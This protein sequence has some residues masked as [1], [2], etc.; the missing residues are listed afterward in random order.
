MKAVFLYVILFFTSPLSY[1]VSDPGGERDGETKDKGHEIAEMLTNNYKKTVSSCGDLEQPAYLCSGVMFRG[2]NPS[3]RYNSWDPSP[4]S[5]KSGGVSFSYLREDAEFN[6]LAFYYQNGFIIYNEYDIPADDMN[7]LNMLCFFPIDGHTGDRDEAGCGE[8]PRYKDVSKP[9]QD[10]GINTAQGWMDRFNNMPAGA[11]EFEYQCGFLVMQDGKYHGTT[12]F[13]QGVEAARQLNKKVLHQDNEVR[14]ATWDTTAAGYPES[15]PVAA[16]FYLYS[17]DKKENSITRGIEGAQHDQLS[18]YKQTG[19]WVPIIRLTLPK[20]ESDETLFAYSSADQK[21]V[22]VSVNIP[23][24]TGDDGR[25]LTRNDYYRLSDLTVD[26]PDYS[27]LDEGDEVTLIWDA[28]RHRYEAG[29]KTVSSAKDVRFSVPRR[30]FLDA[31]GSTVKLS[32]SVRKKAKEEM[33]SSKIFRL[34][35]EKQS[36]DLPAP[37]LDMAST[38]LTVKFKEMTIHDRI[39]IRFEGINQ[40]DP[41]RINGNSDG[42]VNF[43]V[44]AT[45]IN[46]NAGREIYIT[47]A[48]GNDRGERY[49]FSR[50]LRV[51]V[52]G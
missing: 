37:T 3:E 15:F 11:N 23:Q 43:T 10:Q 29:K 18:F 33:Q 31:I 8:H 2:T 30:E 51:L 48:V 16:F 13:Y 38:Q 22:D 12:G 50:V 32:F 5:V 1:A 47:Y 24:A 4:A 52:P 45:W 7:S 46:E 17:T 27:G 49:Q 41:A 35:V 34:S 36:L 42:R 40:H 44:P 6:R 19:I 14:V 20:N 9:C 39:S 25:E 26:I 21:V 28:P